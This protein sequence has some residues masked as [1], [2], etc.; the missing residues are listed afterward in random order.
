MHGHRHQLHNSS[1]IA[2]LTTPVFHPPTPQSPTPSSLTVRLA[3]SSSYMLG[4]HR[5]HSPTFSRWSGKGEEPC[6]PNSRYHPWTKLLY[7]K[8][9]FWRQQLIN[10]LAAVAMVEETKGSCLCLDSSSD[11]FRVVESPQALP[12]PCTS[13][14]STKNRNCCRPSSR[15]QKISNLSI[16]PLSL[17]S[18]HFR[19]NRCLWISK[20]CNGE[21]TM[22]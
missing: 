7:L 9:H 8:E 16:L 4:R 12:S 13:S 11:K 18:S 2:P 17:P 19:S 14:R 20:T 3:F 6:Y 22:H 15:P 21:S 10:R 1:R 5:R